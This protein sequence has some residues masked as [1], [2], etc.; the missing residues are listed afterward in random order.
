VR[1]AVA[2][3][4]RF[5][6][7]PLLER[8]G[9]SG[10]HFA[11]AD[12]RVFSPPDSKQPIVLFPPDTT[13]CASA[14][15]PKAWKKEL[16]EALAG[17][18]LCVFMMTIPFA[19]PL[20]SLT[21]RIDNFGFELVGEGGTG[22]ST[23]Q[24]LMAT[25]A[26]G[27]MPNAP[28][29]YWVD[30]NTTANALE[31]TMMTH[32]DQVIIMD[33]QALFA[34][35]ATDKAWAKSMQELVFKLAAGTS[36]ARFPRGR[37]S[38]HRLIYVMSSNK[39]LERIL[40]GGD[41]AVAAAAADRLITLN[42]D[43]HRPHGVFDHVPN[44]W[45][46][47]SA[48]AEALK[49][50]AANHYGLAFPR[51]IRPLVKRRARDEKKLRRRI[52]KYLEEFRRAAAAD[53]NDGSAL[54]VVDAFGICYAAG[55]LA[56]KFKILPARLDCLR[57]AVVSYSLHL[58]D[59]RWL[60]ALPDRLRWLARE[61]DVIDLDRRLPR[62]STADLYG[63]TAFLRTNRS[64]RR[65]ILFTQ[66]ARDRFFPDF[67]ALKYEPENAGLFKSE[68]GRDT[69]RRQIRKGKKKEAVY[70]FYLPPDEPDDVDMCDEAD[71]L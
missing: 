58:D 1:D 54:R 63:V 9:W 10:A 28:G 56:Q 26:G 2:K 39:P 3:L 55:K 65:E 53:P 5:P 21:T 22:K 34:G 69:V 60:H 16:C 35:G 29:H 31:P 33:E 52:A 64:G 18:H 50:A 38:E 71:P 46:S 25:V 45:E 36:K 23:L 24:Q 4:S 49:N 70:R 37:Q 48:F 43:D 8:P 30:C 12:G 47:A 51:F 59:R 41:A 7:R 11:L 15:T 6:A 68:K 61:P 57:A 62:L 13:K 14:G 44:G 67:D 27:A 40:G 66:A 42:M 20:L 19:P 17:Q 32:S